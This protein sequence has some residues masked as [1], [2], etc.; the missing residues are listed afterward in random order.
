MRVVPIAT[1]YLGPSEPPGKQCH[2]AV[3]IQEHKEKVLGIT[4]VD[5]RIH[6][7]LL[8]S[9]L[10]VCLVFFVLAI[11]SFSH[12]LSNVISIK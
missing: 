11:A 7:D 2:R 12:D 9:R 6:N 8:F 1:H 4:S 10:C 5:K 3:S